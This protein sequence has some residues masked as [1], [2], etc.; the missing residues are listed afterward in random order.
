M[1]REDQY[2]NNVEQ[3]L[4]EAKV[5]LETSRQKYHEQEAIVR[6]LTIQLDSLKSLQQPDARVPI[7]EHKGRKRAS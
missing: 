6:R 5:Q 2:R 3:Q 7:F 4:K 1:S